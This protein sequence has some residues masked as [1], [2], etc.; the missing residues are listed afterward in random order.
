MGSIFFYFNDLACFS[1]VISLTN[2]LRTWSRNL[3]KMQAD[4]III[5]LIS[6]DHTQ[7]WILQRWKRITYLRLE[8]DSHLGLGKEKMS[9]LSSVPSPVLL[10][11]LSENSMLG[12]WQCH[13][14]CNKLCLWGLPR[15]IIGGISAYLSLQPM[16][17]A[18]PSTVC[19]FDGTEEK[20][21]L[22]NVQIWRGG[23]CATAGHFFLYHCTWTALE[24]NSLCCKR[25]G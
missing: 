11:T 7:V 10:A 2:E 12:R 23:F 24:I 4:A 19:L 22:W 18:A 5:F 15:S 25:T 6:F 8:S 21:S 1:P 16:E 13:C 9:P 17:K 3:N 20:C 14:T